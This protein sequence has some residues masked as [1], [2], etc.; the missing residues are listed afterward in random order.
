MANN[1]T[2]FILVDDDPINNLLLKKALEK[3]LSGAEVKDFLE[4]E[5]ALKYI[6]TEFEHNQNEGRK[7]IFLDINMPTLSGWEFLEAFDQFSV[8]IKHQFN[9]YILSSTI[10]PADIQ[11]A[12]NNTL[13]VD[14]IEKPLKKEFL[15]KT[16]C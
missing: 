6:A 13:V 11:R 5:L 8:Q 7:I 3:N 4:P 15:L 1:T 14:F 10:D 12:K 9:I 2:L 16:F